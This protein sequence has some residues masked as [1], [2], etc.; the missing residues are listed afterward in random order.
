MAKRNTSD[1]AYLVW[2]GQYEVV[3][4]EGGCR[5]LMVLVVISHSGSSK[6]RKLILT[7]TA[8]L[9][10]GNPR[11]GKLKPPANRVMERDSQIIS[12]LSGLLQSVGRHRRGAIKRER[13]W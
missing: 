11:V 12:D 4:E 10:F 1:V 6:R 8:F 9:G 7:P 5:H 2:Q 13:P 3:E